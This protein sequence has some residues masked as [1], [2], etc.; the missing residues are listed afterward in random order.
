M[1]PDNKKN[2]HSESPNKTKSK[3]KACRKRKQGIDENGIKST[4]T[5][6]LKNQK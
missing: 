4:S 5:Q 1:Q 3:S 6:I 2:V